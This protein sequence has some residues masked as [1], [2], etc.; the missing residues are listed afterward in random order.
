MSREY[1]DR[2]AALLSRKPGAGFDVETRALMSLGLAEALE[3]HAAALTR[4]AV[5]SDRYASRLVAATW[6]LVFAT[7]VLAAAA[8][9]VFMRG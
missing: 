9:A 6:A 7:V 2:V 5:A 1:R 4:A 8:V 3:D